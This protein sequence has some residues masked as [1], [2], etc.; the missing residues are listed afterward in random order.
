MEAVQYKCP[1]CGAGLK[2]DAEK[3]DFKCEFCD[4]VFNEEDFFEKDNKL[5]SEA[6]TSANAEF[7]NALLYVCPSCG[8]EVVTELYLR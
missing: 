3:Q 6:E 1:A 8:A 7:E 2:F 5:E 4:S